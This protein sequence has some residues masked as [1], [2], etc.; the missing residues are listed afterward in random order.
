MKYYLVPILLSLSACGSMEKQYHKFNTKKQETVV[1]IEQAQVR[2]I[3]EF[4]IRLYQET[5]GLRMIN[6]YS[7]EIILAITALKTVN[8]YLPVIKQI[9]KNNPEIVTIIK[10]WNKYVESYIAN[11]A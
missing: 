3:Q 1:R 2:A 6:N 9:I 8:M 11:Q 5:A 10:D 4:Y 7:D